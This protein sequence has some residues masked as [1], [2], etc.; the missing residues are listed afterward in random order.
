MKILFMGGHKLGGIALQSL[1]SA[2]KNIVGAVITDVDN[3]WYSGVEEV[4]EKYKI[5]IYKEKNINSEEFIN[6]VKQISPDLIVV[7]NFVQILKREI[8]SIPKKGC[9]NTHASLLPKYRGRAPLNW[10]ILN[11]EK[12]TGVTVHYIEDGID[13]GDIV[14]Q[15]KI[16]IKDSDYIADIMLKVEDVYSKIVLRACN[17]I[18]ENRV[19]ALKQDLSLGFYCG[20]RRKEDGEIKWCNQ[21]VRQIN[22][23]VRAV[24]R[25]YPGAYFF[26]KGK[27][28][29]VWRSEILKENINNKG[30]E[31][32]VLFINEKEIIVDCLDGVIKITK[33][34]LDE[35]IDE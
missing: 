7:V 20:K 29:I 1:I 2:N 5:P 15:E 33:F 9:I 18:E 30:E 34:E 8:I 16:Y 27:K 6:K 31:G 35:N 24:S 26:I 14:Q 12:E 10:A 25:P 13:T 11:G 22:N 19:V 17:L 4:C 32:K 23:L 3:I 21:T 28:V